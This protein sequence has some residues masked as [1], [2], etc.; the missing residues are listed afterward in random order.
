[1]YGIL[2]LRHCKA[3]QRESIRLSFFIFMFLVGFVRLAC[4]C[5]EEDS[6]NAL[7]I[8]T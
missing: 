4:I 2:T 8:A 7:E 1:M 6:D 3:N 5:L